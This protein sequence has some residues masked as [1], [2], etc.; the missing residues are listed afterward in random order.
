MRVCVCVYFFSAYACENGGGNLCP[1]GCLIQVLAYS[2][3]QMSGYVRAE[4]D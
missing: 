1:Q 2:T 4:T 3:S